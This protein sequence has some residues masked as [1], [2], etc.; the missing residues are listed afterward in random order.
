MRVADLARDRALIPAVEKAA[1]VL[2]GEAPERAERLTRRW[3]GE[4]LRYG[5]V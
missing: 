5:G 2:L 4:A 1:S 3:V